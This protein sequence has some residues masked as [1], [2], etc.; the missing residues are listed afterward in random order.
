MS[1]AERLNWSLQHYSITHLIASGHF[2]TV[3]HA[4]HVPTGREVAL[5]LIP[6]QGVDSD[7][8]VAAERH[9]AVLQQRFGATHAGLVP[10]VY[11]HQALSPFYAIAMELVQGRQLTT[12]IADGPIPS[13]Q[14]VEIALAIA[15]FLERAHR[16]DTE[17][18]RFA[19]YDADGLGDSDHHWCR[20][21]VICFTHSRARS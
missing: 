6:L 15:R 20:L 2:G 8:K 14:A 5:K 21:R 13:R 9:G 12:L 19:L 11:E 17:Q 3:Y 10:E 16:F 1:S 4:Q 7:E 18:F